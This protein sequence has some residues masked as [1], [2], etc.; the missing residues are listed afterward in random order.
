MLTCAWS[1]GDQHWR[2]LPDLQA[3]SA[4]EVGRPQGRTGDKAIVGGPLWGA[5]GRGVTGHCVW[6]AVE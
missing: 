5:L 6:Q 3:M 2:P 4:R 1:Q